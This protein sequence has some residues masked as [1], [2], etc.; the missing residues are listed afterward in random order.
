MIMTHVRR[1]SRLLVVLPLLLSLV[2][3]GGSGDDGSGQQLLDPNNLS[4]GG[5][6]TVTSGTLV[7]KGPNAESSGNLVVEAGTTTANFTATLR[8]GNAIG[9][10]AGIKD[11]FIRLQVDAG[12]VLGKIA[13]RPDNQGGA[14]TDANGIA[15]FSYIA[16]EDVTETQ[17]VTISA[18]V[19]LGTTDSPNLVEQTFQLLV[20]PPPPPKLTITRS[21]GLTSGNLQVET[22]SFTSG[23]ITT[24]R[25][26][27]SS[28]TAI[29]DTRVDFT[30]TNCRADAE[31]SAPPTNPGSTSANTNGSGQ[32]SF[33]F[34]AP[35]D[36]TRAITCTIT[37]RATVN[38]QQTE[39]AFDVVVKKAPLPLIQLDGPASIAPGV[40]NAGFTAD[41]TFEDGRPLQSPPCIQFSASGA[42]ITP[43][44]EQCS[45]GV[46]GNLAEDL[47]LAFSVQPPANTTT[48]TVVSITATVKINGQTATDTFNTTVKPDSFKFINPLTDNTPVTVGL[49]NPQPLGFEWKRAQGIPQGGGQGVNGR[50]RLTLD[51][52]GFFVL[53][54]NPLAEG[55]S[56]EVTTSEASS[57]NFVETISVAS[58][59]RGQ[60]SIAA[61]EVG[62]S[63][64][65]RRL[66]Q[67]I[68]RATSMNA[69]AQPALIT[70]F[71]F[72]NRFSTINVDVRNQAGDPAAGVDVVFAVTTSTDSAGNNE[73][74]FPLTQTTDSNGKASAT[75]E[76]GRNSG[77]ATVTVRTQ[78]GGVQNLRDVVIQ[79]GTTA[80]T[81]CANDP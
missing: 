56:A 39:A 50:I 9:T 78:T 11:K 1:R 59:R 7:I 81:K 75:Y 74:I 27:E 18:S 32:V 64:T 12:S 17:T 29:R 26:D 43:P 35:A 55:D 79:G 51:G 37:A 57:G 6:T 70:C 33:A 71:P 20:V 22:G 24:L 49:E 2:A 47:P 48:D 44:A 52:E 72:A 3:C 4:G 41:V 77:T 36:L 25:T 61:T 28:P 14:A 38:T 13:G 73:R 42:T 10:G 62:G 80:T 63:R 67:F 66:V 69:S 76:A 15:R 5:G 54:N 16:A 46:F 68:D 58:N 60:A 31:I 30:L 19:D 40:A 45:S 53:N 23:F 8:S 21:D 34:T 65:A